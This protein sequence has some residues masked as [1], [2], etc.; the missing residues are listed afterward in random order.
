MICVNLRHLW[1]ISSPLRFT[2]QSEREQEADGEIERMDEDQ[3]KE[4][5][6]Q[7]TQITT[8]KI[9][10]LDYLRKSASSVDNF[11][12]SPIYRAIGARAGGRW[13]NRTHG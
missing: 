4:N 2:E 11:L 10:P 7:M 9:M 6:P 3:D 5:H 12:S 8:D 13:R 1:I